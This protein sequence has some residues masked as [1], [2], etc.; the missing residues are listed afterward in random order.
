M[1]LRK[2]LEL[3]LEKINTNKIKIKPADL[4][5]YNCSNGTKR[6]LEHVL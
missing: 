6:L 5:V 3:L 4:L 2:G 1:N